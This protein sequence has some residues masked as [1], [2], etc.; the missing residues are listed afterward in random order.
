VIQRDRASESLWYSKWKGWGAVGQFG[1]LSPGESQYF[2]KELRDVRRHGRPIHDVLEV[3]FGNGAFLSYC[4]ERGWNVSGTELGP[5][6]VSAG[7][8]AGFNV[9]P[10]DELARVPE[11]SVDLV[12]AF[13]VL[14]HIPS[15]EIVSFLIELSTKLRDGGMM[16]FR[17]PNA[18]SWL[19][20]A[21][22]NGDPTHVSAIGYLKMAYFA[23]QANLD[24]VK[25]RGATRHGFA[26]SFVNGVYSLVAGPIIAVIALLKRMLYFPGIPVVLS[27]SNVICVVRRR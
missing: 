8:E 5:D 23:L 27:T 7:R 10:A 13:D 20:N 11:K 26:T 22:Q 16:L 6:M 2:G 17:F 12:A 18:D 1:H 14:E 24:I 3:G 25:F 15:D 21:M 19:G 9:F 4:R